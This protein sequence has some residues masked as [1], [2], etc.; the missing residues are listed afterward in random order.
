[1]RALATVAVL[2]AAFAAPTVATPGV[3]SAA[4]HARHPTVTIRMGEFFYRPKHVTVHVGQKV[5]FLNVGKIAHTVADTDAHG[6]V[7]S[8]LIRP[9]ALA[10]GESQTVTFSRP[11]V[12]D[13]LCT[14]HPT[15][16]RGTIDVV[17]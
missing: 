4:G 16:M 12:V 17:R 13:Y 10:H 14:F 2:S 9:R 3:S 7:R 1:V 6:N 15:L 11:G 5:R 8:K